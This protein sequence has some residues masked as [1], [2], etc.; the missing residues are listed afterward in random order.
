MAS[1]QGGEAAAGEARG[2]PAVPDLAEDRSADVKQHALDA[3]PGAPGDQGDLQG[4]P[5]GQEDFVCDS[6]AAV[7]GLLMLQ[8]SIEPEKVGGP[9]ERSHGDGEHSPSMDAKLS[10]GSPEGGL[11]K[12]PSKRGPSRLYQG[13]GHMAEPG[14]CGRENGEAHEANEGVVEERLCG[15]DGRGQETDSQCCTA[16]HTGRNNEDGA[17]SQGEKRGDYE[18]NVYPGHDR[19]MDAVHEAVQGRG[20]VGTEGATPAGRGR[21]F[22]R[23]VYKYKHMAAP[24]SVIKFQ[25]KQCFLGC[26]RTCEMAAHAW[27]VA[28]LKRTM[29]M[30]RSL[31][32]AKLN[33]PLA[34][35]MTSEG[36]MTTLVQSSFETVM[37][38]LRTASDTGRNAGME[39][40][41]KIKSGGS[42]WRKNRK[43][44]A[45]EGLDQPERR[46][47]ADAEADAWPVPYLE[48]GGGGGG[49]Q[50]GQDCKPES[51]EQQTVGELYTR[52]V[53][54]LRTLHTG[55]RA[56]QNSWIKRIRD[57]QKF[58]GV[59][60]SRDGVP[61]SKV[62]LEGKYH[63]LGRFE[64]ME[65]AAR[66]YDLATLKRAML[67]NQNAVSLNFPLEDYTE[68]EELMQFLKTANCDE[69]ASF[70]RS[71]AGNKRTAK[72]DAM[73]KVGHRRQRSGEVTGTAV[74]G[75]RCFLKPGLDQQASQPGW[76]KAEEAEGA[77]HGTAHDLLGLSEAAQ[78]AD[79]HQPDADG[80]ASEAEQT[81]LVQ[82]AISSEP[83]GTLQRIAAIRQRMMDGQG[84]GKGMAKAR[85]LVVNKKMC[86]Q[87]LASRILG[88]HGWTQVSQC[89]FAVLVTAHCG[90]N[91]Q[92]M[93]TLPAAM[94]DWLENNNAKDQILELMDTTGKQQYHVTCT[95]SNGV[96]Q[97]TAGWSNF[98]QE[99]NLELDDV[100]LLV[101]GDCPWKL[102][103]G[104][105]HMPDVVEDLTPQKLT[106]GKGTPSQ[107]ANGQ[108]P[109]H[110]VAA[111]ALALSQ[112]SGQ[113]QMSVQS[114]HI[115]NRLA[116]G[117]VIVRMPMK[118]GGSKTY[119][120]IS[121]P[122]R[123]G[124]GARVCSP[125]VGIP[126]E[127]AD[128]LV[129]R[130]HIGQ[131]V[132]VQGNE[133]Q[134][135]PGMVAGQQKRVQEARSPL[136]VGSPAVVGNGVKAPAV[137]SQGLP[138]PS[139]VVGVPTQ[140][141]GTPGQVHY[142]AQQAAQG[143]PGQIQQRPG[144]PP[145]GQQ[146]AGR[147]ESSP[148]AA[149]VIDLTETPTPQAQ[150]KPGMRFTIPPGVKL[151][152]NCVLVRDNRGQVRMLPRLPDSN[153]AVANGRIVG[154]VDGQGRTV[155]TAGAP[156]TTMGPVF[157][158]QELQP[159]QVRLPQGV[160]Q[161][162]RQGGVLRLASDSHGNPVVFQAVG[163]KRVR[164]GAPDQGLRAR[165][166]KSGPV[167]NGSFQAEG[168]LQDAAQLD[169]DNLD[170]MECSR[171]G[172]CGTDGERVAIADTDQQTPC[173]ANNS[174]FNRG[175]QS[176]SNVQPRNHERVSCSADRPQKEDGAASNSE[177]SGDGLELSALYSK[178]L[179]ILKGCGELS[180]DL[181]QRYKWVFVNQLNKGQQK[182]HV[183]E[184]SELSAEGK[185]H[186]IAAWVENTLTNGQ[187]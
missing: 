11:Q 99:V 162:G 159:G 42:L 183:M 181:V 65:E 169:D 152:D 5:A 125:T 176:T 104:V 138:A 98:V 41:M 145:T 6:P 57:D 63:Y 140:V 97:L 53:K 51:D 22:F 163:S 160:G 13:V 143:R 93:K 165:R 100:L 3:G 70:V 83:D 81:G 131:F 116:D 19:K 10:D 24:Y 117:R 172:G 16:E 36:L 25:G 84:M 108:L 134:R 82:G 67:H 29:E 129:R 133:G 112:H 35:Y 95:R 186:E 87:K 103:Y 156:T 132:S 126:A 54:Q 151:A 142:M 136:A 147:T 115:V 73:P 114:M 124:G 21:N 120:V 27:D 15:G 52:P 157:M 184:L 174:C 14:A 173:T 40:L 127:A 8:H 34:Y 7:A 137:A 43:P 179:K 135:R 101:R 60:F 113:Q 9:V 164:V 50:D 2:A 123:P 149:E 92:S 109:G 85:M 71:L 150:G 153:M 17:Q 90:P 161:Q 47:S 30:G 130:Q 78:Q 89:A 39:D 68:D 175:S 105:F 180:N 121:H 110:P 141:G 76:L 148:P 56:A 144:L 146:R 187:R 48:D 49:A 91:S 58:K 119:M 167:R 64:T 178:L 139:Y 28:S 66:A 61:Y 12:P 168:Q 111:R 59:Y 55:T 69:V 62:E 118:G 88:V 77:L 185:S 74:M 155:L 23:G 171:V 18:R 45:A 94:A 79:E 170:V 122:H 128:R 158:A 32:S 38:Q 166:T 96:C 20:A 86:D 107:G 72:P 106:E 26:Y 102:Q 177:G 1:P 154:R 37:H 4:A 75:R 46:D 182:L 80:G 44:G 33:F 31:S